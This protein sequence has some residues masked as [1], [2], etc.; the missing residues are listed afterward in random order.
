VANKTYWLG[1]LIG[2][3]RVGSIKV[4]GKLYAIGEPFPAD[5]L[6]AGKLSGLKKAGCVGSIP[7]PDAESG[8]DNARDKDIALLQGRLSELKAKSIEDGDTIAGLQLELEAVGDGDCKKCQEKDA[9][10]E[11]K[12]ALIKEQKS[13]IKALKKAA[14]EA[15]K[16]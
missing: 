14:K 3:R 1:E 2:S 7:V 10:I 15:A 16:K 8:Q 11:E 5:K 13:E 4:D 9:D 12:A 6:E